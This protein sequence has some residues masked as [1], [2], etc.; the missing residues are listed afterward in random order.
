MPHPQQPSK[1][2]LETDDYRQS[3]HELASHF[4]TFKNIAATKT[5]YQWSSRIVFY[6]HFQGA[7][8]QDPSRH[9]PWEN[10]VYQPLYGDF[11]DKLRTVPEKCIQRLVLIEDH[12]PALIDLLGAT[13]QIP[14]HVF[15]EHLERSDYTGVWE[16][17]DDATQWH[18]HPS[19]HGYSS[20]TWYCPVLSLVPLTS[21]FQAK[22]I[23]DGA[24]P[25][26]R[27]PIE[28]CEPHNLWL[29]TLANTWRHQLDLCTEPG[30]YYKNSQT[31]Y[32]VGWEER[33]TIWTRELCGCKF[34]T[35]AVSPN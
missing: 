26:V 17:H 35:Y 14:P 23:G 7:Q 22:P 20:V 1:T 25:Q 13:F 24:L 18:T 34:G 9:E 10:S 12:T 31:K 21:K 32:P 33:A 3:V 4:P 2:A 15:E 28:G 30:V 16:R 8:D 19:A 6:D 5:R 11:R 27:C 29:D